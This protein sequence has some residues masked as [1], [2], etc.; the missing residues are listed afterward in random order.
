MGR[1]E[2][3]PSTFYLEMV[4]THLLKFIMSN[5]RVKRLCPKEQPARVGYK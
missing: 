4:L 5:S 2:P 3:S 1:V